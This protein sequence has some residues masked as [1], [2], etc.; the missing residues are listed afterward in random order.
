MALT[1]LWAAVFI[2]PGSVTDTYA[3]CP[4][5]TYASICKK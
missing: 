2:A 3:V 5:E 4:L 1:T